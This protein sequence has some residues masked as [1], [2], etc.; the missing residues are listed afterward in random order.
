MDQDT[1]IKPK[2]A[3]GYI[4]EKK[5]IHQRKDYNNKY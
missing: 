5:S 1:V 3:R 2:Q 4:E